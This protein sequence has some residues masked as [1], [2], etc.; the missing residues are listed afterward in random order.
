MKPKHKVEKTYSTTVGEAGFAW[1][2]PYALTKWGD[3]T[4][5]GWC[6][7]DV[8][9]WTSRERYYHVEAHEWSDKYHETKT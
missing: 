9:K 3:N 5:C 8:T 6:K 2:S 1:R 7:R 4:Y